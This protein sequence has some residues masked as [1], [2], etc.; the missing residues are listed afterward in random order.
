MI[1]IVLSR[2]EINDTHTKSLQQFC[3]VCGGFLQKKYKKYSCSE[4]KE[5][6][7]KAFGVGTTGNTTVV[8]SH[9]CKRCF[10]IMRQI[11]SAQ[12]KGHTYDHSVT[13]FS[14]QPHTKDYTVCDAT[15]SHKTGG[16]PPKKATKRGQTKGTSINKLVDHINTIANHSSLPEL[17]LMELQKDMGSEVACQ[18]CKKMLQNPIKLPCSHHACAGCVKDCLLSSKVLSYPQ[19]N[20]GHPLELS[21]L[22]TPSA[23]LLQLLGK[24]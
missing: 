10:A 2:M 23:L 24:V 1:S 4:H 15:T 17:Q 3:R 12:E 8:P 9:F 14:W 11:I 22:F 20:T 6:L 13:L 5:S 7:G 21:S 18:H 19:C 16:R